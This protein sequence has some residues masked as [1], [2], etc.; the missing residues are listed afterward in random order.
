MS[1]R[2]QSK[3]K[4][5]SSKGNLTKQRNLNR[6]SL[7]YAKTK[8]KRHITFTLKKSLK[9]KTKNIKEKN[10]GNR[11]RKNKKKEIEKSK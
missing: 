3:R 6:K 1:K 11:K 4:N 9:K 5:I 7:F 10:K 8:S 2:K